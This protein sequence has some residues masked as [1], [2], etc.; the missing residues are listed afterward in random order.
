MARRPRRPDTPE[1]DRPEE[2]DGMN[3]PKR[4]LWTLFPAAA[5]LSFA[6]WVALMASTG[7]PAAVIVFVTI[8][9]AGA[10]RACERW[11]Q[12][13]DAMAAARAAT[14]ELSEWRDLP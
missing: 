9:L 2:G 10:W 14:A 3:Q 7:D 11:Y 1:A 6:G 13:R 8:F 4:D 5:L 12:F